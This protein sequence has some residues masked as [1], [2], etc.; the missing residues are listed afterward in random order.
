MDRIFSIFK[1]SYI[2]KKIYS[3]QPSKWFTR[4]KTIFLLVVWLSFTLILMNKG[5][6]VLQYRQ[7]AVSANETKSTLIS[8]RASK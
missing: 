6:K 1:T 3:P 4:G 2:T 5:D 7:M 8:T